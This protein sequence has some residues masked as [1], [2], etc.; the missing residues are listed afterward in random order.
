MP[1]HSIHITFN[2][3]DEEIWQALREEQARRMIAG[4]GQRG[5]FA[6]EIVREALRL[7]LLP[8]KPAKTEHRLGPQEG[9]E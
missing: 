2:D 5:V 4:E 3:E 9:R 6:A 8:D 7:F 1:R